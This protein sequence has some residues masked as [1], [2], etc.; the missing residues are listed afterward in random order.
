VTVTGAPAWITVTSPLPAMGSGM[1]SYSVASN[2]GV[3]RNAT[4]V[5]AGVSYAVLQSGVVIP[6][7]AYCSSQGSSTTYE[8]ISQTTVAGM[9]RSSGNNLGYADFTASAP[10]A[11]VRGSNAASLLPG[12]SSGAYTENW[13]IWIDF[14]HDNVFSDTEIVFSGASS[15]ALNPL[16]VVP[17]SALSGPTRM[18]VSM[19]FGSA[20]PACGAFSYGEVEDYTVLIP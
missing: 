4:L 11:L 13:R 5:I 20:P 2:S 6:P 9:V 18:R 19:S 3:A 1:L 12:F 8:W 10:I 15:G 7:G 14:N 17:A 16:I